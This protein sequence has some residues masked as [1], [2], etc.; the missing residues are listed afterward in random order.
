MHAFIF[1]KEELE[2]L[3]FLESLR[4]QYSEGT[5]RAAKKPEKRKKWNKFKK[6]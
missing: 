6:S 5:C 3:T 1:W 2:N 4:K